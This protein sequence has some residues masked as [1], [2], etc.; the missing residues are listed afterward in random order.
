MHNFVFIHEVD[1]ET[2]FSN[3]FTEILE[4][5]NIL[6]TDNDIVLIK[7]N[8]SDLA[9][10][11]EG[12]TTD[13]KLVK[14]LI[15]E[16]QKQANCKIMIGESDHPISDASR[17]FEILG[18]KELEDEMG[19]ELVNL[20]NDKIVEIS[21]DG[22]FFD[23]LRVS[24]K[25]L[26]ATK[27]INFAKLKTH[28]SMK[29][30][31]CLKNLFGLIPGKFRSHYHPYMNE[32]LYDLSQ[33]FKSDLCIVDGIIGMENFGPS[34]GTKKISNLII[35]GTDDTCVDIVSS[36]I[37]GFRP[38]SVP[39]LKYM[40]KRNKNAKDVRI[41][42]EEQ[43]DKKYKKRF[44]FVP[45]YTYFLK[46]FGFKIRRLGNNINQNLSSLGKFSSEV[47]TGLIVLFKGS[48]ESIKTGKLRRKDAF[49]YGIGLLKKPIKKFRF[50]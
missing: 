36:K 47:G 41:N 34:D 9:S 28:A 20:S 19:V 39:I 24:E 38:K 37:M 10:A 16:I 21:V 8:L 5:N 13:V 6:F 46:N 50:S 11:Y 35:S 22:H 4:Q 49:R 18:Y 48:F 26:K 42:L 12:S 45:W 40:I 14:H 2:N 3:V 1:K 15:K 31:V 43:L 33:V 17:E 27:L 23:T 29:I 25:S 32:V 7:P 44:K 30:T